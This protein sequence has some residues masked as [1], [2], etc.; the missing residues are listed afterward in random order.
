MAN[1]I[2]VRS[3]LLTTNEKLPDRFLFSGK[4]EAESCKNCFLFYLFEISTPWSSSCVKIKKNV[5]DIIQKNFHP[6]DCSDAESIFERI[7]QE[8]NQSLNSLAQKGENSW[9]GNL[10]SIIG[11]VI[12]NDIN[13]AQAGRFSGYIFR[14]SRISS[15]TENSHLKEEPHPLKTFS[16]IT[17][18]RLVA[19]DRVVF[20]NIELYNHFSLDRIRKTVEELSANEA[21]Q[22]FYHA[23]KRNK[24]LT[25]NSIIIEAKSLEKMPDEARVDLPE[26]ITLDKQEESMATVMAKKYSPVVKSFYDKTKKHLAGAKKNL[27]EQI[28]NKRTNSQSLGE[29]SKGK[30][31]LSSSA[32]NIGRGLG[33]M[34][35]KIAPQIE[36]LGKSKQFQKI[37]IKTFPHTSKTAGG[38]TKF[39]QKLSFIPALIQQ[40]L[41]KKNRKYLYGILI[42]LFVFIGYLK[43]NANNSNRTDKKQE[44]Q[45]AL[46]Y[47]KAKEAYA[48]AK[49][50]LALGRNSDTKPL[51]DALALAV[52][53]QKSPSNKNKA[54]ELT[55]EIQTSLDQTTKTNRLYGPKPV[56]SFNDSVGRVVLT[57]LDIYGFDSDGKIYTANVA[58]KEPRLVA[59]IGKENGN[60]I[61][62]N[63]SSSKNKIFIYPSSNKMIEYD[64]TSKT[65]GEM[66]VTDGSGKWE[67]AKAIS[68]F[69]TNVYLL[70]SEAG[71]VWKH[72]ETE[73]GYGKGTSYANANKTS[74]RGAVDLAVDGNIY[75]LLNTGD[76]VKF[77][78]GTLDQGF[79]L[80]NIPAS[81]NKVEIPTKIYTDADTNYI[82]IL[83]K[84]TNRI[85]KFD[86]SGNYV[87]Q[88]VLDNMPID[89]FVVNGKVQKM[90]ILSGGKIFGIDL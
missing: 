72:V 2:L 49:D 39:F 4:V 75:V 66:K 11:L 43:I 65:Q 51:E 31:F 13:I 48:K 87:N 33:A 88:T 36:K 50:D 71:E 42:I 20:G 69:V 84:K 30:G 7:L 70:D 22:E 80:K 64:I 77:I 81:N 38:T 8:I 15:L 26:I 61:S 44:Q 10:N 90:W 89:D 9:I 19:G 34:K 12:E 29:N 24:I 21:L 82:F 53:S 73:T 25:V 85:L 27:S 17:Q 37:K 60:V 1:E 76:V 46:S 47:D 59:S 3:A 58:D 32:R 57:G 79:S 54:I 74:L 68:S 35:E 55:K 16:D 62:A 28:K 83:D 56:F 78:K 52:E 5:L 23:L 86:K 40:L 6:R 41:L 67:D 63:F 14:K 18:G 45:L